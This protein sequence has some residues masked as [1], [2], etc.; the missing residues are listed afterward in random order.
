MPIRLFRIDDRLI[1]G[2]VVVGWGERLGIRIYVVVDDALADEGW[3]RA[4]LASGV[5]ETAGVLF[6]TVEEAVRRL[7]E[8]NDSARTGALLTRRTE[9]M[10]HL[11]EGGSLEGKRVNVGCLGAAPGRR[12]AADYVYLRPEE[13]DD[14]RAIDRLSAGVSARDLPTSRPLSLSTLLVTADDRFR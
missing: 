9:T 12:R 4:L 2:Q 6:L 5:P 13:A 10:R 11:A 8:L 1:H 14:L 7:P 3:E